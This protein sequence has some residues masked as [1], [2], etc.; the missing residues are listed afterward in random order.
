MRSWGI[1][2]SAGLPERRRSNGSTRVT[3]EFSEPEI[4][5]TELATTIESVITHP[6]TERPAWKELQNH[7]K[8]IRKQHLRT[9]FA[10]DPERGQRMRAEAAGVYLDYSKNVLRTRRISSSFNWRKRPA[11]VRG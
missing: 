2:T 6:L 3:Q 11:C 4:R 10:A 7:S 5:R 1:S 9:L 8:K